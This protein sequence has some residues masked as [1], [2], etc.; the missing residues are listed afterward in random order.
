MF[1]HQTRVI[2]RPRLKS[3]YDTQERKRLKGAAKLLART[4]WPGYSFRRAPRGPATPEHRGVSARAGRARGTRV[5]REVACVARGCRVRSAHPFTQYALSALERV[6]IRLVASQVVVWAGGVAT[7]VDALGVDAGGAYVCVELKCSS[8]ARYTGACGRM[9][10]VL[11]SRPDSLEQQHV[12]QAAVTRLLFERTY[13]V[14]AKSVVLRIN[15]GGA[16]VTR[17]PRA[18]DAE[19][20][21]RVIVGPQ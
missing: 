13:G 19:L 1:E 2:F 14:A 7:A 16:T 15:D 8:D 21:L 18:G 11:S 9:R 10:G 20:A 3:F 5:D 12:V 6:G 17:I 4:F